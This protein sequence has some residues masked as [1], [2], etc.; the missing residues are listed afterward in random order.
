MRPLAVLLLVI[1]AVGALIIAL[2]TS[3]GSE[4]EPAGI[5]AEISTPDEPEPPRPNAELANVATIR[6]AAPATD[7]RQTV[8]TDDG[9]A[10]GAYPNELVGRVVDPEGNP[11]EGAKLTLGKSGVSSNMSGLQ[12]L[13]GAQ[14][15]DKQERTW[16]ATS[17]ANGEFRMKSIEPGNGYNLVARHSDFSNTDVPFI[18]IPET[19]EVREELQMKKGIL[20]HGYV[21]NDASQ[22]VAKAQV[23][24]GTLPFLAGLADRPDPDQ[25]ETK[26]DERGYYRFENATAG[27]RTVTARADGF[28]SQTK[29]NVFVG[30]KPSTEVDFRLAQGMIIAGRVFGPDRQGIVGAE[31]EALMYR[32]D[33]TSRGRAV[34]VANG[35]FVIEGLAEGQYQ[36]VVKADGYGQERVNRIESGQTNVDVE[37]AEQGGVMGRVVDAKT[38]APLSTFTCDVRY[39]TNGA[40]VYGRS[41]Q[42]RKFSGRSDG[43]FTIK[44]LE[45]G[46][47]AIMASAQGFAPTFS[48]TFNITQGTLT[49]SVEVRIGQGGTI[50][51]MVMNATTGKPIAGAQIVTNENNWIRSPFTDMLGAAMPRNTTAKTVRT[52]ADGRFAI[53]QLTPESYQIEVT[54]NDFTSEVVNDLRLAENQE[55][56]IGVIRLAAGALIRGTVYDAAGKP[57]AG[58]QVTVSISDTSMAGQTKFYQ[59][60]TGPD[61]RYVIRN[62]AQGQYKISAA[63][64]AGAA[65]TNANPFG[66]IIDMKNSEVETTVLEGAEYV[67]DL[68][69]GE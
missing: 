64:G 5:T 46:T 24:L 36:L 55:L 48:S 38:G 37:L 63:R 1:A 30:G 9:P 67:Q 43:T 8:T 40:N 2:F 44:G 4:P 23:V 31:I 68:Y 7:V 28:G 57:L 50:S 21:R 47:Y 53:Q 16:K 45:Q 6:E 20:V 26:T 25:R 13:F 22:P 10:S 61:G 65:G 15:G 29:Q 42:R 32:A 66:A 11:V 34:S 52:G 19:G 41:A 18:E 60:R 17:D 12:L 35:E 69:I 54:H 39:V 59:S 33:V 62:V 49:P 27:Q 14:N 56:D 3:T 51:G 58:A